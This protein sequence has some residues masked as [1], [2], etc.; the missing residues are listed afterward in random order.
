MWQQFFRDCVLDL[1]R[2]FAGTNFLLQAIVALLQ[3]RKIGE[4][5]LGIDHFNVADRIDGGT[6]MM[7][8]RV[9]ETAH[10][11]DDGVYFADVAEELIAEAFTRARA[12]YQAGDVNEL[13]CRWR[14]FL[15]FGKLSQLFQ[16]QIWN[17]DDADVWID[18]AKG[19]I[20]RRRFM[21]ARNGVKQCRFPDIG[22]TN[23]SRAEHKPRTL[24]RVDACRNASAS[25][26]ARKSLRE[27]CRKLADTARIRA[28]V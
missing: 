14:D 22:Q 5:Q 12:F 16:T 25:I 7:H 21:R 28:A 1:G 24:R 9:L 8:V 15:G 18:R 19:I 3:R 4:H 26:D 17:G 20:F 23:D 11:L 2:L 27:Q 13:N 10:N 6:D